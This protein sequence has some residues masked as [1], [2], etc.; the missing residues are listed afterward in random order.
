M[1]RGVVF[2]NNKA[3]VGGAIAATGLSDFLLT[4]DGR[5]DTIIRNNTACV[6]GGMHFEPGQTAYFR[7]TVSQS[8]ATSMQC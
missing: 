5:A 8:C 2:E 3:L 4:S 7:A 6:G 1:L